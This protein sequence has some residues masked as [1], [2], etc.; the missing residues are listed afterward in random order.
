MSAKD[1]PFAIK[2]AKAHK[3]N[4]IKELI[5]HKAE[6]HRLFLERQERRAA[7]A[8]LKASKAAPAAAKTVTEVADWKEYVAANNGNKAVA[9]AFLGAKGSTMAEKYLPLL[10]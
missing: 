9:F 3:A 6:Q 2:V 7:K 4:A 10:R 5:A 1:V 8:A